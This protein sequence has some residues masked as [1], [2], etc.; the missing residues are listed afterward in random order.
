M[1]VPRGR[2][3][4]REVDIAKGMA[5]FLMIAAHLLGG[6]LLPASTF[7]APLFF[8]CSGMNVVLLIEKTRGNRCYDLFHL[9]FP[10]SCS[11]AASPRSPLSIADP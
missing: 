7:A 3:R 8:A 1:S 9:F 10:C 5:C 2:G 6:K 11:W 4:L